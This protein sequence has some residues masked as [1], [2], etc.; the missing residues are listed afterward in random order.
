MGNAS[1]FH[2]AS[3]RQADGCRMKSATMA[4]I[5]L[6]ISFAL[7]ASACADKPACEDDTLAFVMAHTFVERELKAPASASYPMIMDEGVSVTRVNSDRGAKCAFLVR[8][9][10]D[11]QNSF[12][13][14]I[15][16]PFLVQ[17]SPSDESGR[18]WNLE[19]ILAL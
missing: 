5:V 18:E 11:A 13:A 17:L 3:A 16:T 15:R 2:H 10:V 19:S 9:Y 7:S 1:H 12:G 14:S 8:T 4:R 6:A